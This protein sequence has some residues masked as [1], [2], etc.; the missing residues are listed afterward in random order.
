MTVI[1]SSHILSELE[2]YSTHMLILRGGRLVEQ[3]A[4]A[5]A[6]SAAGAPILLRLA[7][8]DVRLEAVLN[9]AGLAGELAAPKSILAWQ[10]MLDA[11]ERL[12]QAGLKLRDS[13]AVEV[14]M[15]LPVSVSN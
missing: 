11:P 3:R 10:S 9:A 1:V 13:T 2:D 5:A 12:L 6:G 15:A 7:A 8:P 4:L 14:V